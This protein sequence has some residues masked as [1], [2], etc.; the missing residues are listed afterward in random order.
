MLHVANTQ[1][2]IVIWGHLL[3][4]LEKVNFDGFLESLSNCYSLII[5][6]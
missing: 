3:Q 1:S 2:Q 6:E 5:H 4:M